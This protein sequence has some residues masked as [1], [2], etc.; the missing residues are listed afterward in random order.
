MRLGLRG[1]IICFAVA[2]LVVVIGVMFG[3]YYLRARADIRQQYVEKSRSV[4]LTVEATREELEKQW[5]QGIFTPQQLRDW[6]DTDNTDRILSA[7]PVVTAWRA[8]RAKSQ[9]RGYTLRVPAFSP[10]NPENEPDEVE[11][12][13]LRRLAD[14]NLTEYYE[15]DPQINAI[16]YFRPI[17][18]TDECLLCHGDPS[19]STT[20]WAN[21]EGL[22]PTDTKMENRQL[23]DVHGAFELIQPLD[24]ADKQVAAAMSSGIL[25]VGALL[26]VGTGLFLLLLTRQVTRPIRGVLVG[27]NE[28][29]DQVSDASGQVASSSQSVAF[30]ATQQAASLQETSSALEEVAAQARDNANRSREANELA[31]QTRQNASEGE[32]TIAALNEAMDAIDQSSQ[33]VSKIIKVIE[34]IAFQTN[35]L[36]LNA[37]VEAARAGEHGRGFA[38]VADEVRRLATRSAGAARETTTLIDESVTRTK[39]GSVVASNAAAALQAIVR[40]VSSVAE[41]LDGISVASDEQALGVSQINK[42]VTEMDSIT[43][44]NAAG[45]EQSASAAEQLSAQARL[46]KGI[47]D[48]LA[49]LVNGRQR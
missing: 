9:E 47:V 25:V 33:D 5:R 45:S 12:P 34:E 26:V 10:R 27:L 1:K 8:A 18:L 38:V 16:R 35:L 40:D 23:G 3:F 17:R 43:Q 44:A 19:Q 7:V 41:L 14:E 22:D 29:A 24:H 15:I 37:A 2:Q 11:T 13:V 42:A 46:L 6:A 39:E 21:N 36:A 49:M 32:H 20:L 28:G 4:V 30:G 48:K 31:A